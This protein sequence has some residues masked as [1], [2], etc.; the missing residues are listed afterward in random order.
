ML[1]D[2]ALL[3]FEVDLATNE[4]RVVDAPEE[5]GRALEAAGLDA[6][7]L[8]ADVGALD[9]LQST[10]ETQSAAY[11]KA[12]AREKAEQK[13]RGGRAERRRHAEEEDNEQA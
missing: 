7:E 5:G 12:L 11:E 9:A 3:D 4:V 1:E 13:D 10:L 2:E 6:G 8:D